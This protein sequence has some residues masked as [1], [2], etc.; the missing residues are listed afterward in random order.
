LELVGDCGR[1]VVQVDRNIIAT[2]H[3]DP[4]LNRT[5]YRIRGISHIKS[6]I[7]E[8]TRVRIPACDVH[9]FDRHF[10]AAQHDCSWHQE[11]ENDAASY[12]TDEHPKQDNKPGALWLEPFIVDWD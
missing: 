11:E 5:R 10:V 8:G 3:I 9:N 12:E 1:D 4:V 2:G 6:E 7:D